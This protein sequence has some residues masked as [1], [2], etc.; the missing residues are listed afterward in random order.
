MILPIFWLLALMSLA[1]SDPVSNFSIP[2]PSKGA[3]PFSK[4]SGQSSFIVEL[5]HDASLGKRSHD[6]FHKRAVNLNLDYQIQR[7]FTN[8][9]LFYGLSIKIGQNVTL[10]QINNTLKSIPEVVAVYPNRLVSKP[11]PIKSEGKLEA[12]TA[13]KTNPAI[14][15][16]W[17]PVDSSSNLPHITGVD[18][19]SVLKMA[20]VDR[21]HALG[22][23]GKGM[24]IA[25]ID[26]GVDYNHPSLGGGFGPG[27]KV[28]GGYAFV[29]DNWYPHGAD[30]ISSPDPLT[31]CF[32]GGHGTHVSGM[33]L[34][35]AFVLSLMLSRNCGNG[36]P[37]QYRFRDDWSGPR[38]FSLHVQNFQLCFRRHNIRYYHGCYDESGR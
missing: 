24:K 29:D 15:Q 11:A 1:S 19:A 23:K 7:E 5:R 28:A 17:T 33:L 21:V 20:D 22:I 9:S 18:T 31:T 38:S 2:T 32:E 16:T 35:M 27:F 34:E 26:T 13:I 3:F 36:R 14:N 25:F 37:S 8:P 6:E 12:P 10:S 30:P 4:Q